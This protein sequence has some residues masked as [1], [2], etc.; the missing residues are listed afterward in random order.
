MVEYLQKE[1]D[2]L[3]TL[4]TKVEEIMDIPGIVTFCIHKGVSLITCS[5]VFPDSIGKL[6]KIKK[7]PDP[8]SFVYDLNVYLKHLPED[9][10]K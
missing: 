3:I 10:T 6:L 5:D 4:E 7:V 9:K 1:I 8:E 2:D